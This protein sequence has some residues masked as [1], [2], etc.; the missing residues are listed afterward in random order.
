MNMFFVI[1]VVLIIS[2]L[3][4]TQN[5]E[6]SALPPKSN[7]GCCGHAVGGDKSSGSI[8]GIGEYPWMGSVEYRKKDDTIKLLCG[9]VLISGKYVLSG[10]NC[11]SEAAFKIGTPVRIRLG[12][13]DVNNDGPD[14][15]E[16][17]GGGKNCTDGAISIPI[18]KYTVHPNYNK[19]SNRQNDIVLIKLARMAPYTDFIRPICLPSLDITQKAPK[20][21]YMTVAGWGAVNATVSRSNVLRRV[22]VP[23]VDFYLCRHAY[24]KTQFNA[25]LSNGQLCAGGKNRDSCRGD[26]GGPLMLLKGQTTELAGIVSFG[27]T[28][29]GREDFPGVYTKVFAYNDWI[30][31]IIENDEKVPTK[32][33]E[34]SV[35]TKTSTEPPVTTKTST[36]KVFVSDLIV[37]RE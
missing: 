11:F 32:T 36:E 31:T 12:D 7:S 16:T 18:E 29:C 10:A 27:P 4:Y 34:P 14:C 5:C 2:D 15:V 24:N 9:A 13:Y 21:L 8:A 33:A 19:N 20:K 3:G 37:F 1:S 25:Q 22:H 30:K 17:A 6:L 35:T 26:S 28:P 23:Y